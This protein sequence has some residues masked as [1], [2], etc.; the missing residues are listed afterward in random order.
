M[1]GRGKRRGIALGLLLCAATLVL[2]VLLQRAGYLA[3]LNSDMA[4]ETILARRQ[5]DT[6]SLVQMDWLY[7]T[8]IH[9]LHM[10]LF[11]ALAFLVTPS[12]EMARILGNMLGFLLG[13][14]A[15]VWLCRVMRL[16]WGAALC[17]AALLP[18]AAG[19]IYALNMT[20]G[21]YYI[22]HLSLGFS[23]VALWLPLADRGAGRTAVF[24][25]FSFLLGFLS[26]RY[27][28]CFV[29]PMLAA[30]A[31][32]VIFARGDSP[33]LARRARFAAKTGVGFIACALGYAASLV[34][35][36]RLFVSGV[37]G[38]SSF[39]FNP[40]DGPMTVQMLANVAV[41]FLKLIGWRGGVQLFSVAGVVNLCVAGMIFFGI[42]LL[43]RALRGAQE[44][45]DD[46]RARR[47][48][49]LYA[50]AALLVNLFCF[51]FI[52]GAYINRYLILAVIFFA[53]ALPAALSL[54]RNAR[55]KAVFLIMLCAGLSL[56]AAQLLRD[57]RA[58][59]PGARERG[60]GMMEAVAA[61]EEAG[62]THGYGTF[63]N[64]RVMQECSQGELTFT[65]V[66]PS[67]TEE[68]AIVSCAPEFIRWLEPDGAS[69]LDAC[70]GETFLIL[71]HA[72]ARELSQW[73]SM[74]GAPVI[75][76]NGEYVAYGF[77]SS[78]AFVTNALLGK[79]TLEEGDAIALGDGGLEAIALGERGRLRVPPSYREA[80]RY[81][82]RFTCE[83]EP[84]RDAVAR[85]YIGSD[86]TLLAEQPLRE[87]ENLFE[88]ALEHSD[89]Y[90]M[91]Q[92]LAGEGEIRLTDVRLEKARD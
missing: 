19:T 32:D 67:P 57:T 36:P 92:L 66:V 20:I 29:C 64:V 34:I 7:S 1:N 28:L 85:A 71:T 84:A 69:A 81:A 31:L 25:A 24:A 89:Q 49:L 46:G 80:G 76:K 15:L 73:L 87:G 21:G 45:T 44:E 18:L 61:L 82:L 48:M 43:A 6:G 74:T 59:A 65:G 3:Y 68:G 14:A 51:V 17:T 75:F 60:A 47:M 38:A 11:Y 23:L 8:E 13:M 4:S 2:A 40:V 88:F 56:S 22:I 26:V 72:E 78:Q 86:F 30:A 12:F 53:P 10:N 79:A 33:A 77:A 5:V 37:G 52:E 83:G 16:S 39:L 55:L 54:E 9:S 70:D 35:L 62:Y 42:A 90:F 91:V 50:C 63:W 41:D 27:V 58:E